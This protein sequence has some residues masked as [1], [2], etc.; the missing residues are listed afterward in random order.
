MEEL[1]DFYAEPYDPQR[2]KIN[3]DETNKQLIK[4]TRA[5]VPSMP[6]Q[7]ER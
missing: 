5:P 6:G 7:V 4:E 2:P 1:L 3:F